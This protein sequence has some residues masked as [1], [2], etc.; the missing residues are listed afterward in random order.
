VVQTLA[1]SGAAVVV[2]PLPP[3]RAEDWSSSRRCCYATAACYNRQP[4]PANHA[5]RMHAQNH[6]QETLLGVGHHYLGLLR[7]AH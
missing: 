6:L 7:W 5:V 2:L 3:S 4:P 1:R